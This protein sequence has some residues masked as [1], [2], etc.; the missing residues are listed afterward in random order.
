MTP[1]NSPTAAS[2]TAVP[3]TASAHPATQTRTVRGR[4]G[5]TARRLLDALM[6]SL[7]SPHI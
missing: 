3:L 1:A 2:S 5:S 7:A 4:V 6:R